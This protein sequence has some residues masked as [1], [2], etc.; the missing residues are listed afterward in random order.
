MDELAGTENR[1]AVE[2]MR[3]NDMVREMSKQSQFILITHNKHTME[4]VDTLHG[5]SVS[6]AQP[7]GSLT[8]SFIRMTL[9]SL[10]GSQ[11]DGVLSLDSSPISHH[12]TKVWIPAPTTH[13]ARVRPRFLDRWD[14]G[15]SATSTAW[16]SARTLGPPRRNAM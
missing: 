2:R 6:S 16:T 15:L 3:Y 13:R 9:A 1:I 11:L 10:A 8:C 12:V 7:P 14:A 5:V 4:V